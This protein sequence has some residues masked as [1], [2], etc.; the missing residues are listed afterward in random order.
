MTALRPC[1]IVDSTCNSVRLVAP[2]SRARPQPRPNP[3]RRRTDER[4]KG[5][6]HT[7]TA[8]FR[9][10]GR[11]DR[12]RW[13]V[14]LA[15]VTVLA[16]I[17]LL[18]SGCASSSPAPP[19]SLPVPKTG[20]ITF[21]LSL[22]ASTARLSAAAAKVAAPGSSTYRH[23]SSPAAAAGQ[24]GATDAQISAIA[25]SVQSLGLQ[26]AADPTR[27]FGRVSGS[28]RQWQA[29][30]GTPLTEQAA[31]ASNPF[32]SYSLPSQHARRTAALRH[33]SAAAGGRA[34]RPLRGGASAVRRA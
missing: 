26:Y 18:A 14:A 4:H 9:A 5:D 12:M 16:V 13:Y 8:L 6:G 32:I 29:A 22:P 33:Q 21:T 25:R 1:V 15:T 7:R 20:E 10:A 11:S 34:V 2:P 31:T 23:F 19:V 17:S 3:P 27:L 30:L 24:F 28:A